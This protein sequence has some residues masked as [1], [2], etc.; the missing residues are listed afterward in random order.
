MRSSYAKRHQRPGHL[1]QGRFRGELIEDESYFWIV[2]RYLH[3]HD[4]AGLFGL[5]HPDSVSHLI[6]R[7]EKALVQVQDV[8]RT[9]II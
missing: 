2:S 9:G 8:K 7:A 3:L 5:S 1:F 6:R 4:L